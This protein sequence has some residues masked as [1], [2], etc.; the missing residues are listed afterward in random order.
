MINETRQY[1]K[2]AALSLDTFTYFSILYI[3][4]YDYIITSEA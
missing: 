4:S 1:T 2:K 3:S